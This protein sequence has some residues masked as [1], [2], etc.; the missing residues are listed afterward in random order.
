MS[1]R[2]DRK[3]EVIIWQETESYVSDEVIANCCS[4]FQQWAYCLHDKD[5]NED[6]TPKKSHYHFVGKL[7]SPRDPSTVASKCGVPLAGL[8]NIRSWKAAVRYLVHADSP[9]KHQYSYYSVSAS[10][11]LDSY[12]GLSD[13]EQAN[14]IFEFITSHRGCKVSD[15]TAWA[16]GNGCYSGFRRGFAVW[17]QVIKESR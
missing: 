13:T 16:L 5:I 15:V 7:S 3:F 9:E 11:P 14:K 4:Y 6:L 17:A 2:Q 8:A 12:L 10:F 1:L